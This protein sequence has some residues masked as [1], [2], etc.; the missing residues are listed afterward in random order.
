VRGETRSL[1]VDK[2]EA[3]TAHMRD[4]FERAAAAHRVT[5]ETGTHTARVETRIARD[6]ERLFLPDDVPVVRLLQSAA[7][8][9]G[10]SFR[11]RASGG[12]SDANVFNAAGIQ[13]A[14]LGCGMRDIHT[15]NEW[16]DVK[17]M[18]TTSQLLVETLRLHAES[19]A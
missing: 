11:T 9:L 4:C 7:A 19:P 13:V 18:V 3:Q 6:Y 10:R 1:D 15:V 12:G 17:D 16:I 5:L 14:N 8:K 2:L